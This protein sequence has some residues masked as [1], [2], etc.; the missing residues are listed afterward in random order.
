ME[1]CKDMFQIPPE[2]P[3]KPWNGLLSLSY[4]RLEAARP[5]AAAHMS[6]HSTYN[7]K[8][9]RYLTP[10]FKVGEKPV[11]FSCEARRQTRWSVVGDGGG[12]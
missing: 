1:T 6:L 12:L 4:L 5:R 8:E 3:V 11:W 9:Q 2:K 7:E 10:A